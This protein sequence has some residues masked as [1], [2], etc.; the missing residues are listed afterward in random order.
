[1]QKTADTDSG[2]IY[3]RGNSFRAR[4]EARQREYRTQVIREAAGRYGHFLNDS[5][6]ERGAN[7]LTSDAFLTAR[8]RA[9]A[10][11]GVAARTFNNMLSSQAMCFNLFAPLCADLDLASAVVRIH[12]PTIHRVTRLTIEYTPDRDVFNDQVGPSGVDCDVLI[13]GETIDGSGVLCVMETKFVEPGFSNCGFRKPGRTVCPD[14]APVCDTRSACLYVSKK[15][16]R[17]WERT[18]QHALLRGDAFPASGCP[19]TGSLWQIWVNHA[20]AKEEA[21]RRGTAKAFIAVCAPAQNRE[22]LEDGKVLAAYRNLLTDS[23]EVVFVAL[24]DIIQTLGH[25]ATAFPVAIQSWAQA[26]SDRYAN[27]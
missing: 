18:D 27:I 21:A 26:M 4:A 19:F 20:L 24:D 15:K 1:V 11:K 16:F 10:G 17:Y 23:N 14:D 12:L 6:A 9:A 2:R 7:F 3:T 22:L 8:K 25:V 13:E 5:A